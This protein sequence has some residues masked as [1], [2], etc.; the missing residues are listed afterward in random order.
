MWWRRLSSSSWASESGRNWNLSDCE[1]GCWL[2]TGCRSQSASD[3]LGSSWHRNHLWGSQ[4]KGNIHW[5]GRKKPC[6][7]Q[8]LE[9]RIGRL[10]GVFL[11]TGTHITHITLGHNQDLQ[12][13]ISEGTTPPTLKHRVYFYAH[14]TLYCIRHPGMQ[15][16]AGC[17]TTVFYYALT[18]CINTK[19]QQVS[20]LNCLQQWPFE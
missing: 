2:Q 10:V 19:N 1:C 12:N 14:W 3:L 7:C 18:L 16:D 20:Y 5:A 8:G 4:V 9:V 6:R 13:S 11:E 17:E 15:E